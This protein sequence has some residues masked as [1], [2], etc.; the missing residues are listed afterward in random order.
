MRPRSLRT[1][2]IVGIAV[3]AG[4]VVLGAQAA[5]VV[6][7]RSWLVNRIDAQ[8]IAAPVPAEAMPPPPAAVLPSDFRVVVYDAAGQRGRTLGAGA[9]PGPLLPAGPPAAPA[10]FTVPAESGD[11]NWRVFARSGPDGGTIVV[12]LPLDTVDGAVGNL[13]WLDAGLLLAALI[14]VVLLGHV[15]VHIGLRPLARMARIAGDITAHDLSRRIADEDAHTETGRLGVVLNTMLDRLEAALRQTRADEERLRRFVADAGHELR[16]PLTTIQGFAQLALRDGPHD[17]DERREADRVIA[18]DAERMSRLID[19]LI[20]LASLDGTDPAGRPAARDLA[21]V[22]LLELAAEV[23]GSAAAHPS[24]HRLRLTARDGGD[25]LEPVRA[26][27]DAQ[28]LHQVIT[29]L[30]T[31]AL[32]HTGPDSPVEVRVGTGVAG[33]ETGGVD[34]PGRYSPLPPLIAGTPVGVVEVADRGPG[35]SPEDAVRVF[36]RFYRVDTSR[37]R[38]LGGSGLGLAIAVTIV[39]GHG[40][41][42]EVDTGPG[43]GAVFRMLLS[44]PTED[45]DTRTTR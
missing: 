3:L 15:V 29:N 28:R 36:A 32:R 31:N 9:H 38:D 41:R 19:D 12:A 1:R 8:L 14:A 35:L 25:R 30:L 5:G 6:V 33:P 20:L 7:T 2:L 4:V 17:R 34:A 40:G 26:R 43:R 45:P 37:S 42:L 16:T 22:D 18:R 10:P 44:S 39:E 21:E 24:S 13:I 11:G 23:V 27:G